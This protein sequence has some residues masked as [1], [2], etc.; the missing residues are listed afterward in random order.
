MLVM[1]VASEWEHVVRGGPIWTEILM[2]SANQGAIGLLAGGIF[3]VYLRAAHRNQSLSSI[4]V[5]VTTCVGALLAFGIW[6]VLDALP[7]IPSGGG[8]LGGWIAATLL[9]G[10]SAG[11]TLALALRSHRSDSTEEDTGHSSA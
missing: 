11:A 7:G 2:S 6:P 1:Q 10:I 3:S 4:R 9:G 5:G 8:G